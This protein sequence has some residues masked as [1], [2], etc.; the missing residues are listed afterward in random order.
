MSMQLKA[1]DSNRDKVIITY[2]NQLIPTHHLSD[3]G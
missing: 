1:I 2:F 3:H